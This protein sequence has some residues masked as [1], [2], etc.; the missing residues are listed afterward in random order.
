MPVT[1]TWDNSEKTTLCYRLEGRWSWEEL[2]QTLADSRK[3]WST[4]NHVVDVIVDV[5]ASPGFPPGNILGHFRNVSAFY[6]DAKAGNT[7]VV[8]ANDFFRMTLDLF[9]KVYIRQRQ[10]PHGDSILV[11]DMDAARAALAKRRKGANSSS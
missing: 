9:Y 3:L 5:S 4:V 7:V 2:Y 8:G 1:Y 11:K 10:P 6:A